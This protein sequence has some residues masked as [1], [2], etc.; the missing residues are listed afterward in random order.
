MLDIELPPSSQKCDFLASIV[1]YI[2]SGKL[3]EVY[4]CNNHNIT[5]E[6]NEQDLDSCSFMYTGIC[7][8]ANF[9]STPVQKRKSWAE[10]DTTFQRFL[11]SIQYFVVLLSFDL[12]P[13]HELNIEWWTLNQAGNISSM[14]SLLHI[15]TLNLQKLL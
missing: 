9:P 1:K 4:S 10:T 5:G 2:Y 15:H 11:Y 6:V 7:F 12:M 8:Q 3:L 14:I 13:P